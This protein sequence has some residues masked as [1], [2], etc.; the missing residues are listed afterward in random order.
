MV[1]CLVYFR[2]F[3]WGRPLYRRLA[4]DSDE[5]LVEALSSCGIIGRWW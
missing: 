4:G 3:T 2:G 5:L 1:E